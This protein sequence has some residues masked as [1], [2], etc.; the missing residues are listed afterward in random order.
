MNTALKNL[1]LGEFHDILPGTVVK[2]GEENALELFYTAKRILNDYKSRVFLHLAMNSSVA[3][4]GEFPIFVFNY[5][6]H[7][8][9]VPVEFEF[10]LPDQNWSEEFEYEPRVY[11]DGKELV[12]QQI[13]ERSTLN[14]DWRKRVIVET[15]LNSLG[16]TRLSV[17]VEQVPKKTKTHFIA[18]IEKSFNEDIPDEITLFR[19]D[20]SAD[21]WAMSPEEREFLGKNPQEFSIM[22]QKQAEE[23]C[24]AEGIL[25]FHITEEGKILRSYEK[26]YKFGDNNAVIEYKKYKNQPFTDVKITV[27]FVGKNELI[28][29]RIP[30][31]V[32]EI[33]G[34][35]PYIVEAKPTKGEMTFQKWVGV[36]AADGKV[37][38]IINDCVYGGTAGD[39]YIELTLLRGAGYC[40]HPIRS[41]DLYPKD[42][43]LPR[44]DSGRYEFN[45]RLFT[46]SVEEVCEQAELFAMQPYAVNVFPTGGGMVASNVEVDKGVIVSAFFKS[47]N[48]G[49]V[50]RLWNPY[51]NKKEINVRVGKLRS[52]VS[53]NPY[54]IVSL[55]IDEEI[56]IINNEIIM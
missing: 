48:G 38:A 19:Y 5:A 12:C 14:L 51:E 3:E 4:N 11:S 26:L 13:K 24:K 36:K 7:K 2:D 55:K 18:D 39:G 22:T 47:D 54:E 28:R 50:M 41:R 42:R 43:Y 30:M 20:D 29:A 17:K 40:F 31:P 35:G 46:G 34:D 16:M 8:L 45:L 15:P 44:I 37:H 9:N 52:V 32:G 23:F 1:L 53:V 49:Y 27:E 56:K 10:S 21:P 25:P 6:A 33:I